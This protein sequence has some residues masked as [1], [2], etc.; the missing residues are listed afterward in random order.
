MKLK[1]RDIVE[2]SQPLNNLMTKEMTIKTSY[3][4]SKLL[5]TV[6]AEL[7]RFDEQRIKLIKKYGKKQEDDNYQIDQNDKEALSK[8]NKE[9]DEL[10]E[11][12]VELGNYTP[13]KLSEFGDLKIS[14]MDMLKLQP[15]IDG[16][17]N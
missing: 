5:D 14:A 12:E 15:F 2:S 6:I 1:L 11:L 17:G 10:L 13:I 4:M 3:K 16:E 7:K 8:F 9:I